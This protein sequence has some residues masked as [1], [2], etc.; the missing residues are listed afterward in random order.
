MTPQF[1]HAGHWL[2]QML[3]LM[4]VLAMVGAILWAKVRARR[5]PV[6]DHEVTQDRSE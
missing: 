2:A 6:D 5:Y 4:P 1:A 3:Y